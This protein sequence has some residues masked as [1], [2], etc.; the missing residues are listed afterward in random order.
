AGIVLGAIPAM[1]GGEDAIGGGLQRHMEVL[2]DAI[3]G[4]EEVDKV[5][6]NV[7]R[8]NG[9]DAKAF[10]GSFVENAAEEIFKFDAGREVAAVGA[11]VDATEN[12]FA[13]RQRQRC[14]LGVDRQECLSHREALDFPNDFGGRKTAALAA[15]KGDDA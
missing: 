4:S 7:E 6:S 9:A 13:G 5:L 15:H 2:G 1:H 11:E 12:D 3:S 8:L 14:G 10:E